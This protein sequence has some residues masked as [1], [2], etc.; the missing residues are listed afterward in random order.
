MRKK[1]GRRVRICSHTAARTAAKKRFG[2]R[3]AP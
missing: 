2:K 1:F 3:K